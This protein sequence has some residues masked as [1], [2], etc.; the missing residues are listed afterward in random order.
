MADASV[1][2]HFLRKIAGHGS[3]TTTQRYLHPDK[4]SITDVGAA[5]TAHLSA[6]WWTQAE[7]AATRET[8][9]PAGLATLVADLIAGR[10]PVTPIA[11]PWHH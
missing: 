6:H 2:V 5:L 9:Y 4:P 1:P 3:L 11:L 8:I 10:L 7:L